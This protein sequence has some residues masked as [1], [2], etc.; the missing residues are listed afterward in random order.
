MR[1]NA[2]G[3]LFLFAFLFVALGVY[4][5]LRRRR[6]GAAAE[7]VASWFRVT[8]DA[9]QVHLDVRA[10]AP[11]QA[12]FAFADVVRVCIKGEPPPV[13]DGLYVFVRG[14][15]A[16][17]A[18]PLE[19]EGAEALMWELS[20]RGLLPAEVIERAMASAEGVFCWPAGGPPPP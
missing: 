11:W 7:D 8:F 1:G 6:R 2:P 13:S 19:G 10:A 9:A 15:D 12:S 14:R 17:Y 5:A 3:L 20:R 4:A 16:S 18:I